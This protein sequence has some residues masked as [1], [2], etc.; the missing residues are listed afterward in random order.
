MLH[1]FYLVIF[2]LKISK[3]SCDC[4]FYVFRHR[5]HICQFNFFSKLGNVV[6]LFLTLSN[7]PLKFLEISNISNYNLLMTNLTIR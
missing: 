2:I 5:F 3:I 4:K 1:F 7:L 6:L